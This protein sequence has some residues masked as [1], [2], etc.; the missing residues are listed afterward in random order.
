MKCH[1]KWIKKDQ[2]VSTKIKM[3]KKKQKKKKTNCINKAQNG[4]KKTKLYQQRS[5]WIKKNKKKKK[6][7]YKQGS[8]WIKKRPNCINK[9]QNGSKKNK[10]YPLRS[11]WINRITEIRIQ[12]V[13]SDGYKI[14][15]T[16][17]SFLGNVEE[18]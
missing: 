6:K 15:A 18:F 3:D 13:I 16:A 11:K 17:K 12:N 14:F 7:L 5:K 10:L 2:I 1:P 8:K 9:D 4:S